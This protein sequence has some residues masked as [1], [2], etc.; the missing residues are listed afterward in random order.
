MSSKSKPLLARIAH[1]LVAPVG[2]T[3]ESLATELASW[4]GPINDKPHWLWGGH[5]TPKGIPMVWNGTQSEQVCRVLFA[6]IYGRPLLSS[7]RI[8]GVCGESL[9]V[10]P[11][12]R[13]PQAVRGPD[14]YVEKLPD[15]NR[16]ESSETVD[17]LVKLFRAGWDFEKLINQGKDFNM[18]VDANMIYDA[19]A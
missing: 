16:A 19:E 5:A 13:Q 15:H 17:D 11:F 4:T 8:V 9:C 10:S 1:K 14:G 6:A 12:H 18:V 7:W 3:E 2:M